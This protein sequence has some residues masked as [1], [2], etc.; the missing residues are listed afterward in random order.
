MFSCVLLR[1]A[2]E[3]VASEGCLKPNPA[4]RN[5]TRPEMRVTAN[6]TAQAH[7][8]VSRK[9]LYTVMMLGEQ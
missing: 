8:R 7:P 2:H 5:T 6:H 9:F 3:G 4:R 1:A